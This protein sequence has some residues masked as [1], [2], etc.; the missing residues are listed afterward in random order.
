MSVS[1][2]S[3]VT[4]TLSEWDNKR[5][6]LKL[7]RDSVKAFT[8]QLDNLT[9]SLN[10]STKALQDL[11]KKYQK[12]N[13]SLTEL[14][15]QQVERESNANMIEGL[16]NQNKSIVAE[17][18]KLKEE[19]EQVKELKTKLKQLTDQVASERLELDKNKLEK[20]QLN[21]DLVSLKSTVETQKNTATGYLTRISQ[22]STTIKRLNTK[23]ESLNQ[24]IQ[25]L[26]IELGDKDAT[27]TKYNFIKRQQ[28]DGLIA[29]MNQRMQSGEIT[30]RQ[31]YDVQKML[32]SVNELTGLFPDESQ[33]ISTQDRFNNYLTVTA[34]ILEAQRTLTSDY[35]L[36][37]VTQALNGLNNQQA[38][39]NNNF[40][41]M[42]G[43]VISLKNV[44]KSYCSDYKE[45]KGTILRYVDV[46][47]KEAK[48]GTNKQDALAIINRV[49]TKYEKYPY[50][51]AFFTDK[52]RVAEGQQSNETFPPLRADITCPN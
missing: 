1:A 21:K 42:Q 43:R 34:A 44:L 4:I 37:M 13:Q 14:K 7:L 10:D 29:D 25:R 17:Y 30:D 39:I 12:A 9:A 48:E 20:E 27:L 46:K 2:Q 18:R 41:T 51:V 11:R 38:V 52:L 32:K 33:L 28:V 23:V 6:S 47:V 35:D 49:I 3:K 40:M 22:D 26:N 36:T 50:L 24:D 5:D 31:E 19:N 8:P 15:E 45:V 16:Q